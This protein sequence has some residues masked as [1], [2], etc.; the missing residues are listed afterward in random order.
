MT[1]ETQRNCSASVKSTKKIF[2]VC[3]REWG[4]MGGWRDGVEV[5]R[6]K[7]SGVLVVVGVRVE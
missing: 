4:E 3:R 1:G 7:V 2:G 5:M 6:E